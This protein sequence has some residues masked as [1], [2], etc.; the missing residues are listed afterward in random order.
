MRKKIMVVDDEQSGGSQ[1]KLEELQRGLITFFNGCAARDNQPRVKRQAGRAKG[2]GKEW[3][4]VALYA[5]P[6]CCIDY[7]PDAD[8][9]C[10]PYRGSI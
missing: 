4:D 2:R 8:L 3:I 10:E 1:R 9:A 5:A 7:V 6:G